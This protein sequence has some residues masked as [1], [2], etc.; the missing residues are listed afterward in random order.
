MSTE[1]NQKNAIL[2]AAAELFSKKGYAAADLDEI[3]DRANVA[4]ESLERFFPTKALLGAAWLDRIHT[5]SVGRHSE[6]LRDGRSPERKIRDYFEALKPWLLRNKFLGCPFTT[7]GSR[8]SLICPQVAE[9]VEEHKDYIR[10]FLTQL[11]VSF[12][13]NQ[14]TGRRLGAALY[15]LYSGATTEAATLRSTE[16]V[17]SALAVLDTMLPQWQ[18][19]LSN[20]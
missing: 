6:A 2:E 5:G 16:P 10:E 1:S 15:L 3:A 20:T 17:E 12:L 9:V 8:E 14:E 18:S 4:R 19:T 13:G 7:V 11:A